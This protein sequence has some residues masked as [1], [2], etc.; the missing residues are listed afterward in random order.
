MFESAPD[1]VMRSRATAWRTPASGSPG[2]GRQPQNLDVVSAST[3]LPPVRPVPPGGRGADRPST[4]A[5]VAARTGVSESTVA[6]VLKGSHLVN[7]ATRKH[8]QAAIAELE[9]GP[10]RATRGRGFRRM[11]TI[12]DVASRAGVGE[13]TVS[14]VFNGSGLV[15]EMTRQRVQ[16]AIEELDYRPSP[17]ARGLSRGRAMT[18]GVIAPFF[19]R[20]S[21][22][23]RLRGAEARFTVAGYDT[24]LYNISTPE[25]IREQFGNVARGRTDGI[26][27]I[28]V[29]PPAGALER[30]IGGGTPI[31]LVDVRY[32]GLSQVHTDDVEGGTVATRHLLELGHRR[33]AFVGDFIDNPYGFTSSAYRCAGFEQTMRRAGLPVPIY[34]VKEGEHSREIALRLASELLALP[35][36]PTAIFAASDTQAVGVLEA[37]ARAGVDVPG[38]LSV[39]G[40]DDIGMAAYVGLTTVR[41][42]LEYSGARGAQLLLDLSQGWQP[43]EPLVEKLPL[44]LVVRRTTAEAPR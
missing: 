21:A 2:A 32:P 42:P 31:V 14:R 8:V 23:E 29:P 43:Q 12:A 44:E 39:L 34:Y 36:P 1:A 41:Q 13:A 7:E 6:R 3:Y 20:P 38:Q 28:S 17:I 27:L 33:I 5:D 10:D 9:Y 4:I 11:A 16:A 19:V 22:V 35:E 30:L 15:R 18:L 25:Q 24:V 37:A 26:L 40:F